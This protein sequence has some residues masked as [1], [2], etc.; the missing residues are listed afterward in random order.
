M[1]KVPAALA[2]VALALFA[3]PTGAEEATGASPQKEDAAPPAVRIEVHGIAVEPGTDTPAVVL[4]TLD[5]AKFLPIFIGQ[6]EAAAIWRY[7]NNVETPRP[8]T[9]D[10]LADVIQKLGGKPRKVTVTALINGTFHARIDIAVGQKII[11]IDSRPS[12]A[13]ALALKTN[14]EVYV[15]TQVMEKAGRPAQGREKPP[16]KGRPELE[17]PPETPEAI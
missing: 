12:D 14:A 17:I 16:E 2:A 7:A 11:S 13:I 4:A 1:S 9:H 6:N 5:K 8:M 3:A 10:L 15:A